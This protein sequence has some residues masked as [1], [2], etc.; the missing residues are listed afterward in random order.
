MQL[1]QLL[2]PP[3]FEDRRDALSAATIHVVGLVVIMGAGAWL[4]GG[5]LVFETKPISLIACAI[6]MAAAALAVRLGRQ[7]QLR[8]AGWIL[9]LSVWAAMTL[10]AVASG[11]VLTRAFGGYAVAVVVAGLM[12]GGRAAFTTATISAGVGAWLAFY[13]VYPSTL[14]LPS[15]ESVVAT[16]IARSAYLLAIAGL[17]AYGRSRID[18]ALDTAASKEVQLVARNRELETSRERFRLLTESTPDLIS[19]TTA[20]GKVLY[21][22]PNYESTLGFRP[23]EV[24]GTSFVELIHPEDIG[25]IVEGTLDAGN[26]TPFYSTAFRARHKDGTWRW[27]E[28]SGNSFL[29]AD[30]SPRA[31]SVTRD[32]TER[33]QLEERLRQSQKLEAVGRLAG[34]IAHDFNNLLTVIS[35]YGELVLEQEDTGGSR[36]EIEEMHAAALRGERLTRQL[37]AFSRQQVLYPRVLDV[38]QLLSEMHSMLQRILGEDVEILAASEPGSPR[39]LADPSQLEQV[40]VNL[41]VNA[42][43]AMPDGGRLRTTTRTVKLE[44]DQ[45]PESVEDPV[46]QW[47]V[48]TVSDNGLGMDLVTREHAFEPFFTTKEQGRGTGLGLAT[49]H[50]IVEQSGGWITIESELGQ[51][52]TFDIYLPLALEDAPAPDE[53]P[54]RRDV[55]DATVGTVLVA[56]DDDALRRLIERA[57]REAGYEVHTA[58]NGAEALQLALQAENPF[59]LLLTDVVMPEMGGVALRDRLAQAR[60]ETAVLFMSGYTEHPS[61]HGPSITPDDP[62]LEKPFTPSQLVATVSTFLSEASER[63]QND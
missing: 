32:V 12:L 14:P 48:L 27:F 36:E 20:D 35:G 28:S 51:G 43:D 42:R 56:E 2:T 7:R 47:V 52:S 6:L 26:A 63:R 11:N 54:P 58:R 46:D 50:G 8:P 41:A 33:I 9:L 21:A 4:V 62:L 59:D 23:E 30:G 53:E 3:T 13:G 22:S 17:L 61:H 31:I 60:P 37:L 25:P 1:R 10:P 34:G 29:A 55:V 44:P 39:V 57:L 45:V 5:T 15:G 24:I 19:E 16:W 49:V 38:N 18:W 40:I